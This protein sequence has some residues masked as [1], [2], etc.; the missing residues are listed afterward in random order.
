LPNKIH[1]MKSPFIIALVIISL[2]G[3]VFPL[4]GD[5]LKTDYVT[6]TVTKLTEQQLVKGSAE[7]MKTEIRYLVITDKETFICENNLFM[8]KF[9]NSDIFYHLKE[10]QTYTF[11][12]SGYGK[13]FFFDYRNILEIN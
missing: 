12:V 6:C 8:G 3:L 4:V 10:G 11:K 2:V 9:N 5:N 1:N 13:S 7:N